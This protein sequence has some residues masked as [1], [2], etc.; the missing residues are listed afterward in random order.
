MEGTTPKTCITEE[1]SEWQALFVLA[2][3]QMALPM[4]YGTTR[5]LPE[6]QAQPEEFRR[7]VRR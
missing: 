2:A 4:V 1:P 6:F 3:Q 5:A 7:E